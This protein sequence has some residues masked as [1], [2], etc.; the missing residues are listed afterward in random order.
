MNQETDE[1]IDMKV[2][3]YD[4]YDA[5][6]ISMF[7][8]YIN[9]GKDQTKIAGVCNTNTYSLNKGILKYGQKGKQAVNKEPSQLH[10]RETFKP[11]MPSKLTKEENRKAISSL[12]LLTEKRD[13]T[14]KAR[15]CANGSTHRSY[16]NK[17]EAASP[18]V[19]TEA[20]LTT[21][22]IDAKQNRD[23]ITL[24]IPNAFVQTP[25]PK[26]QKRVIMRINRLLLD[27]LEEIC[28]ETYRKYITHQ[29]N[30]KVLYVE[31]KK[32]L[33]G[34]MLSSLLFYKHFLKDLGSIGFEVNPY[35]ICVANRTIKVYQQT[36][37]WHVDD[38]KISHI[39]PE[40]NKEFFNWCEEK[41]GSDLNKHVKVVK[42]K[43]HEYL[44]MK[45][46]YSIP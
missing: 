22:V 23:V 45:L 9:I 39:S 44:A 26:N 28:P 20:L 5:K 31:M 10:N 38:V 6:I 24:D 15:A 35:D 41:Y 17:E 34:M 43:I 25:M 16:I 37:T 8:Q 2:K 36:V 18:T 32:A 46:N 29:N 40:V 3:E 11:M 13:G 12:I 30:T 14:I 42:E 7:M 33:H 21:A 1:A 27:Y 19:S 4:K